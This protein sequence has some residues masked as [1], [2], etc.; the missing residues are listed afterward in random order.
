MSTAVLTVDG[1]SV[2]L[3]GP[4]GPVGPVGPVGPTGELNP[5]VV[6]S[7]DITGTV[8]LAA[9]ASALAK[10]TKIINFSGEIHL[11]DHATPFIAVNLYGF[12]S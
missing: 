7:G 6:G 2:D 10:G 4:P 12:G 3:I 9:I 8:D 5:W 1:I 11:G